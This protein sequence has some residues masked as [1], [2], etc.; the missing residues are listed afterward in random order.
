[1]AIPHSN[2]GQPTAD[3]DVLLVE[4]ELDLARS[5]EEYLETFG[6]SVIHRTRAE[7]ALTDLTTITPTVIL[8]DVGL[9]GMSGFALCAQIRKSAPQIS[10]IFISART[11]EADQVFGLDLGADDYLTKPYSLHLLLAKVRRALSRARQNTP[12]PALATEEQ[13]QHDAIIDNGYLRHDTL[14]GRT[15][16]DGHE[17]HLTAIE[18]RILDYLARHSG[19]VCSKKE[20]I[21]AVWGDSYTSE[22]TLTVH[23]RRLR[24]RIEKDPQNPQCIR[25]VWGRGYLFAHPTEEPQ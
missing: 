7:D 15:W 10:I 19:Q 5:T 18:H 2:G 24:G 23:M 8:L 11:S 3:I 12:I 13:S 16:I 1:M 25:T 20:I 22:G 17:I 9:P 14:A 21:M 4:D 6:I